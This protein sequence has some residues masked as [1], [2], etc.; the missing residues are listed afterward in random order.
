MSERLR[1]FK[2]YESMPERTELEKRDKQILK[3]FLV[4]NLCASAIARRND[5]AIVC[6]SNRKRGEQLAGGSI[7]RI[8]YTHCPY[9]RLERNDRT[10]DQRVILTHRR[11]RT[12]SKHIKQCAFCGSKEDLEEHHMIPIKLGGDSDERNLVFLC[13]KCHLQVT[14]YQKQ[15][16]KT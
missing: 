7:L 13:H 4:D 5:P 8:I 3:Y 16:R 12:E 2:Y 9:L 14:Q 10:K 1:A 6:Y 11:K 15:I